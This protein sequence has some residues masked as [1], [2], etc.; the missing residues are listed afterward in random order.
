MRRSGARVPEGALRELP[1]RAPSGV[2]L[3]MA[4]RLLRASC[5]PPFRPAF[6]CSKSLPAILC[7]EQQASLLTYLE[8]N[9]AFSLLLIDIDHFKQFNATQGHAVG[10][11]VLRYVAHILK[12]GIKGDDMVAR[13]GGEEFVV[14]LPTTDYEDAIAV[15]T[16][17]RERVA[18][19]NLIDS[20][21]EQKSY[22]HVTISIGA[23][24]MCIKDDSDSVV[25][26]ADKALYLAKQVGRNR[27][28][29]EREL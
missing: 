7:T 27:V 15:G 19:K 17:L 6:G 16:K 20:S 26:R 28:C 3:Q 18:S 11:K 29:G 23:S 21:D 25:K 13:Y 12:G 8:D 14:L 10:D 24:V 4:R 5:P 22:G 9:S 2:Q 1:R